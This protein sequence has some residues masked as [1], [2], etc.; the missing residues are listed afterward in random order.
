MLFCIFCHTHSQLTS[1]LL[2]K[3]DKNNKSKH[4]DSLELLENNDDKEEM[5]DT[6]ADDLIS[7]DG[8]SQL[9]GSNNSINSMNSATSGTKTFSRPKNLSFM[10]TSFSL[11]SI[12]SH[13]SSTKP[14]VSK[15]QVRPNNHPL[16]SPCVEKAQP[17][18]SHDNEYSGKKKQE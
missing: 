7:C 1:S 11:H 18:S 17:S 8:Q 5:K 10:P 16:V 4:H 3:R 6:L 2:E 9:N 14:A 13:Q 15:R 12:K